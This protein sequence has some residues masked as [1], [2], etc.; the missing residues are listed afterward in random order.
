MK[1]RGSFDYIA[2]RPVV[3]LAALVAV[4]AGAEVFLDARRLPLV[5]PDL[6]ARQ[7]YEAMELDRAGARQEAVRLLKEALRQEGSS[8]YRW[9]DLG[10][11]LA[12]KQDIEP[13]R[14]CFRRAL[15]LGP[16]I[17]P[18]WMRAAN[19]HLQLGEA[20]QVLQ[21]TSRVLALVEDYDQLI[22]S[23]YGL[24]GIP[25]LEV[26][27]SGMPQE[28]R[29]VV[30]YMRHLLARGSADEMR[31]GWNWIAARSFS[32]GDDGLAG[33]YVAA[34]LAKRL[35]RDAA[36]AWARH[37]G[38]RRGNYLRPERLFNGD[39]E[40]APTD[41]TLDWRILPV[42]GVEASRGSVV[43]F[44]GKYALR[45]RFEGE[46][47]VSY[48]HTS[49]MVWVTAGEYRFEAR[50]RTEGITTNKGLRFRI[51]DAEAARRLD[52]LTDELVGTHDWKRV[53]RVFT[54]PAETNLVTIQLIREPSLKFDNKIKGTGWVDA[55]SLM[56]L[57][58]R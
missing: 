11:M 32:S 50:M 30:S 27:R 10:E 40:Y 2:E 31:L 29:A 47:N 42:E 45:V 51:F 43:R 49:Q 17:P 28:R 26:L 24:M 41:T 35:Y 36:E 20:A 12:D 53:E 13:A 46:A 6:L 21:C 52:L 44:S 48:A 37:V 54:V 1:L 34:L 39:F 58:R 3:L 56:P 5:R 38:E 16:Q 9:C 14:W 19:F 25:V 22:F 57:G 33:E 15:E 23:Y 7:A 18:V 8:P 55:V 4:L